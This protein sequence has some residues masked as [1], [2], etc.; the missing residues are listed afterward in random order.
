M[1]DLRHLIRVADD[2]DLENKADWDD[3]SSTSTYTESE[4]QYIQ[5]RD[6]KSKRRMRRAL[7]RKLKKKR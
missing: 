5:P 2:E 1:L 4:L 7:E 3:Y 6:G